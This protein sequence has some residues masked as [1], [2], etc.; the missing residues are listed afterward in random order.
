MSFSN[1]PLYFEEKVIND[2]GKLSGSGIS[3]K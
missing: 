3:E 2:M 1:K